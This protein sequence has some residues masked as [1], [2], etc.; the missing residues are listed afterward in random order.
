M[1]TTQKK[2]LAKVP[3]TLADDK[4]RELLFT[5]AE[6]HEIGTLTKPDAE[7]NTDPRGFARIVQLGLRHA[8][9]D[10]TVE[11]VE[12]LIDMPNFQYYQECVAEAANP[13]N[14]MAQATQV[15]NG[16]ATS[17]IGANSS[18]FAGSNSA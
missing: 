10:L 1:P 16:V 14:A 18:P 6:L 9:P 3:I 13:P 4:P 15:I 17:Q 5:L 11:Q 2:R 12:R 8:E 7:G